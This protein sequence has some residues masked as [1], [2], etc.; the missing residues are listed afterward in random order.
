MGNGWALR[1]W[2]TYQSK[3]PDSAIVYC[4]HAKEGNGD[5]R[6]LDYAN[7]SVISPYPFM[8]TQRG[9]YRVHQQGY[10]R[11]DA[12]SQ[13]GSSTITRMAIFII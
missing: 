8:F 1:G 3:L 5:I 7:N 4:H 6:G 12:L 11:C 9:P 13:Y 10:S 2:L